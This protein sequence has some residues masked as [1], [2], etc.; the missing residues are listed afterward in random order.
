MNDYQAAAQAIE[1]AHAL[2]ILAGA[3]IGV[4]SGLPDFRGKEGFWKA[5]PMLQDSDLRFVDMAN[6][7]QFIRDPELAWGFYG[8]RLN[9]YRATQPHQGFHILKDWATTRPGGYFIYTSN[10]DGQ[11]QKAGFDA[12]RIYECHGS[13]N[14][15]QT[16]YG[17]GEVISAEGFNIDVDESTLRAKNLITDPASG[18][19]LRP[20][21]LMF[22]DWHWQGERYDE[23]EQRYKDFVKPMRSNKATKVALIEIGAGTAIP[24]VQMQAKQLRN[25]LDAT[26][27][28]IN[29]VL[30]HRADI[31]LAMPALAALQQIQAYMG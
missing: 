26:Y 9:L 23:Q 3:G 16:L 7:E 27:I 29:P 12:N 13:I 2:I 15:L 1:Q 18:K 14:H 25:N 22:N 8:H 28:Q 31:G 10:V 5:Y 21:I 24:T 20:N 30:N 6:P 11:F 17:T 19:V 4:D